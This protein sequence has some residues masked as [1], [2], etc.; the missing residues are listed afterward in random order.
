MDARDFWYVLAESKELGS[1]NPIARELMDEWI[2][3]FRDKNG[4]PAA[5]QDRCLHRSIQLSKGQVRDGR[6][7]CP[8]HGWTYDGSGTVVRVPSEG[9]DRPRRSR[10]ARGYETIE[11]DDFIYVRL[12]SDRAEIRPFQMPCYR[13]TGYTTI[14]LQN[15]FANTVTNCAENF[16]DIP[17]TTFV[18][19][20]IFRNPSNEKL[21][22]VVIRANGSVKVDYG[23]E[24]KNFGI[25]SWFLNPSSREIR[26]TDEFH[27][28]NVTSVN[29]WFGGTRH[30]IITSQSVPLRRNKTRVYTDLTFNYGVWNRLARPLVRRQGQMI[31]DQDIEIL[32]WQ[33]RCIEKF[34]T[35]F[36]N[37]PADVIHTFIE[38]IQAEI[39][40]GR[41]PR[42]LPEKTSEIE[43]WI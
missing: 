12:K 7:T 43:F 20:H 22:A 29:Y 38:S 27:M 16:V 2:V 1:R 18:H 4:K 21:S 31:I 3:L 9:P 13:Q 10:C 6:L 26:H 5:L 30:F 11:Q 42:L 19:P 15:E 41:D 36:Q 40:A 35:S 25:F 17:H 37:S 39:E 8:Y 34:G 14:R 32:G 28:P 24:K 33:N 23:G